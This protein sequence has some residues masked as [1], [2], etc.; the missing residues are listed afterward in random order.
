MK[1]LKINNDFIV[2]HFGKNLVSEMRSDATDPIKQVEIY[3]S[4]LLTRTIAKVTKDDVT[5]T[6][7]EDIK[8]RLDTEDKIE[9]FKLAQG[10]QAVYE[11]N[12]AINSLVLDEHSG[13][14]QDWNRDC[15]RILRHILGFNHP[16]LFT[17]Y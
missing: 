12:N 2:N 9:M 11:Y 10:Y 8:A 5:V 15:I 7:V 1:N 14:S 4:A 3:C 6:C 13:V 17:R 16:T